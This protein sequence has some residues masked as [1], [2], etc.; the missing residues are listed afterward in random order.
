MGLLDGVLGNVLGGALGGAAPQGQG[1][2]AQGQG[3]GQGLGGMFLQIALQLMQQNGGLSGILDRLKQ[4]GLGGQVASWVS[5]G[6]NQPVSA[7]QVGKALGPELLAQLA[8]QSGMDQGQVSQGLAEVLPQ[9]VNQMTPDGQVPE[10]QSSLI[11]N[12]LQALLKGSFGSSS[13]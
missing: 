6:P 5:T 9:L 1:Q 3:Q 10:N 8:G 11:E 12:G 4:S 2:S 7:D 13:G